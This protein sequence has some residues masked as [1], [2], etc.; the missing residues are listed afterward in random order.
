MKRKNKIVG[1][2]IASLLLGGVFISFKSSDDRNFQIVKSL[3]IFNSVFKELDMFYV[4]TIDPKEIIEYGIQ[5]ML[6]KTDPYTDY[7]PEE[8]NTLKE[9]TTGM[10]VLA[11]VIIAVQTANSKNT[12]FIGIMFFYQNSQQRYYFFLNCTN[13]L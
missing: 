9:M 8:D 12:F 5:A 10:Y 3:D 13:F 7:Y 11:C 6:S 1:I 4:D 2:M